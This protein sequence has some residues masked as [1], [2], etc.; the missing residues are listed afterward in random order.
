MS[1]APQDLGWTDAPDRTP[2]PAHGVHTCATCPGCQTDGRLMDYEHGHETTTID[3]HHAT[4]MMSAIHRGTGAKLDAFAHLTP[5]EIL[6]AVE[7]LAARLPGQVDGTAPLAY[8]LLLAVRALKHERNTDLPTRDALARLR[9][10]CPG[11]DVLAE[12]A[13]DAALAVALGCTPAGVE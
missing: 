5:Q 4:M 8:L 1:R 6:H 2:C 13:K 12:R 3:K 11:V 10:S 9:A 7:L